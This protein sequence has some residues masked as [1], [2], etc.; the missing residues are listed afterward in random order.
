[1]KPDLMAYMLMEKCIQDKLHGDINHDLWIL[2]ELATRV[3]H[4][5]EFGVRGGVSTTAFLAAQP[6]VVKSYDLEPCPNHA[7]LVEAKGRVAWSFIIG[8]T[9]DVVIEPTDLLF[10]DTLHTYEQLSAELARHAKQVSRYIVLH[11]TISFG[12][13]GEDGSEPGLIQAYS[14]FLKAN[15]QWRVYLVSM[16]QNGLTVLARRQGA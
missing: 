1:M 6:R 11:D 4:I 5:T 14:D 15:P 16:A 9:L 3:S 8:N 10:I 2:Y 13:K 12:S 7:M